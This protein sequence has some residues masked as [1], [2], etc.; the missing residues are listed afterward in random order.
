MRKRWKRKSGYVTPNLTVSK[1]E[2]I[3]EDLF[4]SP[5]Y[6]DWDDWR[7]GFRD[8]F[9][10][11]KKIKKVNPRR[12]LFNEELYE[13]RVRMNKKQKK[14]LRRRKAVRYMKNLRGS[15]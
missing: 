15:Y 13:K 4:I 1:K 5:H 12:K 2:L 7:D 6:S 8:W 11:F 14:L 10:D 9:D 3:E